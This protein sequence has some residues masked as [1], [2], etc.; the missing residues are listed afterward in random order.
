M[1]SKQLKSFLQQS[2]SFR[3]EHISFY[4]RLLEGTYPDTDRLIPTDFKT[5]AI[6]IQTNS[7]IQWSGLV[8]CQ[9]QLRM[10]Q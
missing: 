8:F 5:M 4:T 7:A 3:S 2:D 10:A 9:M 6:L 1:I